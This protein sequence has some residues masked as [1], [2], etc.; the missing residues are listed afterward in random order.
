MKKIALI[1]VS[2]CMFVCLYSHKQGVHQY[3][4]R[5]AFNLLRLSLGQDCEALDEMETTYLGFDQTN[6]NALVPS[7]GEPFIVSG[8]HMEDEFDIVYHYGS[9]TIPN[10]ENV[11]PWAENFLYGSVV[12]N[13]N[14]HRTITHFWDAD[15]GPNAQTHLSDT[16]TI[17][18][19]SGTWAF[20]IN[21]NAYQKIERYIDGNFV[22]R[23]LWPE[24]TIWT[25]VNP[26]QT[27][28][29]LDVE[30]PDIVSM[31]HGN[32]NSHYISYGD[33]WGDISSCNI[34]V[35]IGNSGKQLAYNR[36]G[37]IC[38]LLQD[39]SIPAHVHETSHADQHGMYSDY[40]GLGF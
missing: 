34:N 11:P 9:F 38:H 30:L 15:S 1:L 26:P 14:S 29:Y 13:R 6:S 25:L 12:N 37:R 33:V 39:M 2:C 10:Y 32:G 28:T 23:R 21:E 31:Y 27:I 4:T 18:S 19:L 3:I 7:L 8:A 40:S 35:P 22:E 36:L 20:V 16:I 5:E 17:G 24:G